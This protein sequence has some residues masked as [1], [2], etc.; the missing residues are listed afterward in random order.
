MSGGVRKSKRIKRNDGAALVSLTGALIVECIVKDI[1]VTGARISVAVPEA[2][3]DYFKL[4]IQNQDELSPK[5]RVRWRY[6]NEL[7]V[8]FFNRA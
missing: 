2:V 6:G 7:G 8:E 4:R 3:P 1:S 5:C